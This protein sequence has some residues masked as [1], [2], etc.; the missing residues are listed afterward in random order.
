MLFA[1]F[2]HFQRVLL[3]S[4]IFEC[5]KRSYNEPKSTNKCKKEP[6]RAKEYQSALNSI[7]LNQKGIGLIEK[8]GLVLQICSGTS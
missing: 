6:N 3:P 2:D 7:K 8:S 5:P 1:A 4:Y